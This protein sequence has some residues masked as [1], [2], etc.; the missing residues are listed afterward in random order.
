LFYFFERASEYVRA[1]I[2]GN[3][4]TGYRITVTHPDGKETHETFNSSEDVH[5][6]WLA[7][8]EQFQADGWWGPSGRD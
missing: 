8:Q 1:E 7:L 2:T 6:R 4:K 5:A 3:R